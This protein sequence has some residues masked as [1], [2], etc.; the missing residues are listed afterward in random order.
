M[1]KSAHFRVHSKRPNLLGEMD[2]LA[3]TQT[4]NDLPAI[5][6]PPRTLDFD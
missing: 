4:N 6:T 1:Q 2:E 5:A 3:G